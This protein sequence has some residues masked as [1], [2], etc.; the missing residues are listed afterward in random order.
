MSETNSPSLF[1]KINKWLII[2]LIIAIVPLSFGAIYFHFLLADVTEKVELLKNVEINLHEVNEADDY[3]LTARR[4][5]YEVNKIIVYYALILAFINGIYFLFNRQLKNFIRPAFLI[6]IGGLVFLYHHTIFFDSKLK[7]FNDKNG[8][9]WFYYGYQI[10][11]HIGF[12][13][14]PLFVASQAIAYFDEYKETNDEVTL[15]Y[16]RNCIDFLIEDRVIEGKATYYTGD[17]PLV[18]YD[19]PV[20]WKCGLTNSRVILAMMAAHEESGDSTYLDIAHSVLYP[21]TIPITEGGLNIKLS[22]KSWW[23]CE[24]PRPNGD[25][26]MVLN[27]MLSILIAMHKYYDYSNDPLAI[28][29]YEKGLVALKEKLPLF[30]DNGF[31]YYDLKKKSAGKS[32]HMIHLSLLKQIYAIE[33]DPLFEEYRIK[34]Q[35]YA[36]EQ[37]W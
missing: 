6:L 34:W 10:D 31:S 4:W 27:G 23:F 17:F 13:R 25:S 7:T 9:E 21:F 19:E 15:T 14:N 24:Y 26:P 1:M 8:V 22:D 2:I 37:G 29:L 33:P 5:V 35:A 12:Q 28:K 36:T 30:D 3:M 16:F 18:A 11:Q 20:G 32:Y